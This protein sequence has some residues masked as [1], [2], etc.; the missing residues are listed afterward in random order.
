MLV[1]TTVLQMKTSR[2]KMTVTLQFDVDSTASGR[3]GC[4]AAGMGGSLDT[5]S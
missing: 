1:A 2:I 4:E 5:V 3:E